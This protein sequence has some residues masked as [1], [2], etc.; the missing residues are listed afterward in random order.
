MFGPIALQS[1]KIIRISKLASELFENLPVFLR[2]LVPYFADEMA[3]KIRCNAIV[4]QQR[5][6]YIEQESDASRRS[7]AFHFFQ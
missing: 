6:V 3:L 5:V 7:I 2:S 1:A 4:I